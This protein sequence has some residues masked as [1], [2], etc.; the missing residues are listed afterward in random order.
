MKNTDNIEK[1]LTPQCEF[2]TSSSLKDRILESAAQS[3]PQQMQPARKVHRINFRRWMT[4]CAAAV[5]VIAL[6]LIFRPGTT[7]MYAATKFFNAAIEYFTEHPAFTATIEVRTDS[8]E[9]FSYIDMRCRF[10]EHTFSVEP[11]T[12]RW[13]LAKSGRIAVN[14]GQFIWQWLPDY[15][16]GWKTDGTNLGVIE[17]FAFLL[18]PASLLKSEEAIASQTEGSVLKKSEDANTI[19]LVVTTPPQ[20]KYIDRVG[21]NSSI[22]ESD[23]K[24]EYTFDKTT[25]RLLTLEIYAKAYGI[26]RKIVKMTDINYDAPIS[27]TAFDVPDGIQWTDNTREGIIRSANGLPVDK[28]IGL[29][30]EETIKLMFEALNTWDQDILGVVLRGS[31]LQAVSQIYKGCILEE[32]GSAFRSGVY[33]GVFVPCKVRRADGKVENLAVAMRK[34]NPWNIWINDG[35]L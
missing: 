2:K 17:D 11:Q 4:S 19:T 22:I 8:E 6:V 33:N 20:G 23:T 9:N 30:A 25:G 26:T 29:S 35:G 13:S 32:C 12:G 18:N 15:A 14:D 16:F 27:Q 34:D 5:A 3:E 1:M 10:V 7:P 28:F 21:L 24:R 31:D